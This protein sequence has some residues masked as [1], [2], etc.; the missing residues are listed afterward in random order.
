MRQ[1]KPSAA[2]LTHTFSHFQLAIE[3]WLIHVDS[4]GHHVAEVLHFWDLFAAPDAIVRALAEPR[5]N[6]IALGVLIRTG[7][8]VDWMRT[9]ELEPGQ[10]VALTSRRYPVQG[11]P[12]LKVF[13]E[14]IYSTLTGRA[15]VDAARQ[16]GEIAVLRALMA[17]HIGAE[18]NLKP[19]IAAA[20]LLW[21]DAARDLIQQAKAAEVPVIQCV[22]LARTLYTNKLGASIPR[23]TLQAVA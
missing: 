23:D 9:A 4:C 17:R 5:P 10:L 1:C 20:A 19:N 8:L 2:S 15:P 21:V 14:N 12:E 22:W 6:Q 16:A 11:T 3:P 13:I 18:L 7:Y